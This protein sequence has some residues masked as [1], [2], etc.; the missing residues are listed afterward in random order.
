MV[1]CH[2]WTYS[3]LLVRFPPKLRFE[4]D[5][6]FNYSVRSRELRIIDRWPMNLL[7]LRS[8]NSDLARSSKFEVLR[9]SKYS[10]GRSSPKF[11]VRRSSKF[12]VSHVRSRI[13][14]TLNFTL[15]PKKTVDVISKLVIM[16]CKFYCSYQKTSSTSLD[17]T[18]NM[19]QFW[20]A[21]VT[22]FRHD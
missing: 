9:S 20:S 19:K 4:T 18:R 5:D 14:S 12:E 22:C 2:Q 1:L 11:E 6:L 13:C 16:S 17:T 21:C 15:K 10:E 8:S 7:E 3:R